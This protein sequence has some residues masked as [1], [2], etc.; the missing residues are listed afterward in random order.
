LQPFFPHSDNEGWGDTKK[1]AEA[2]G[3]EFD[4][5]VSSEVIHSCTYK[6][7]NPP[8]ATQQVISLSGDCA[9]RSAHTLQ[10]SAKGGTR[11]LFIF[12]Y[13]IGGY[14][15]HFANPVDPSVLDA[16]EGAA[17]CSKMQHN[18]MYI[19]KQLILS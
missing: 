3:R 14:I 15:I 8:P 1:A 17:L 10:I 7:Y 2:I 19:K 6:I 18:L 5:V 13:L 12:I 16:G 11:L 9:K 4:P